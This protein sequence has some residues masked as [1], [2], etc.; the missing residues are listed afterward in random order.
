MSFE[1]IQI[2]SS[3]IKLTIILFEHQ[4]GLIKEYIIPGF[5]HLHIKYLLFNVISELHEQH[6]IVQNLGLYYKY[7]QVFLQG[8]P[9][10]PDSIIKTSSTLTF[11]VTFQ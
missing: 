10:D 11:I 5:H 9:A 1:D 6:I 7:S 2:K 8:Q 4:I 3:V